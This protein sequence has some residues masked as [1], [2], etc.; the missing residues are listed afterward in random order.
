MD[1]ARH[2]RNYNL[3]SWTGITLGLIVYIVALTG[4]FALFD[5]EIKTWEDP[6]LRVAVA[7][8]T[9]PIADVFS[10]WV[11]ETS[12][13]GTELEFVRLNYPT[14]YTPYFW[15]FIQ[16]HDEN[17]EHVNANQKWHAATGEPIAE[18]GN[19][20][21]YW[22]LNIHRDF[23]WP[24]FLGGRQIGRWLVGIIGVV[25]MLAILSGVIA[26]TKIREEAYSMRL[27]RSQRLKWQD[28][29]KVVGLW[30]LPFY[31]MIAFTGAFL[32]V[33]GLVSQL[34]AAIA[35]KGDIETLLGAVLG[36]EVER[37]GVQ[38]Q[39]LS[40]D[41]IAQM[42]HPES[43]AKPQ[44]FVVRN[45]G[46]ETSEIDIFYAPDTQLSTV[47]II[48]VDGVT[49]VPITGD[50][51][52]VQPVAGHFVNA[53]SPLHY[54]TYGGIWLKF[55]YFALGL[56]LSVITALGCMMWIERRKY[57][58]DGT[59][60]EAFYNRLGYFNTGVIMGL[61]V[62]AISIFYLDKLYVGAESARLAATGSVYLG[63]WII[64]LAYAFVRRNDYSTT[65]ELLM[66]TGA[67]AMGLP[68]LNCLTTGDWF[69]AHLNAD[70]ST[71]AWVDAGMLV[72]GTMTVVAGFLAP[73]ERKAKRR[74]GART[75]TE[76][77]GVAV[78]AE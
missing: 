42:R 34:T 8:E 3:H 39:M 40:A 77:E 35:F 32:G 68:V 46:D 74:P 2:L 78:P 16:Y 60:S 38:V 56:S 5:N 55:L 26:H 20:L 66:L 49:G 18:R 13:G 22:T 30:G 65:R 45:Y 17:D 23:M 67:L 50:P 1:R 27:K 10:T 75:A 62:A 73:A 25:L 43:N 11:E 54:G 71:A 15:G 29:H 72:L 7:D 63:V 4:T 33:I 21:S 76:P 44:S 52:K 57:G 37:S 64:G 9:P 41:E 48:S 19:G 61:P 47:E 36:P 24:S 6:T 51:F 59:K 12:A 70:H 58:N 28:S 53:M 69:F 31:S 14:T